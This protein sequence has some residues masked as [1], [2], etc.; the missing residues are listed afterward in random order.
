MHFMDIIKRN[1]VMTTTKSIFDVINTISHNNELIFII[2]D[3]QVD[4]KFA[5]LVQ[6]LESQNIICKLEK[7]NNELHIIIKE[8]AYKSSFISRSSWVPRILFAVVT[9]LVM[10]DGYYKTIE[11]N[12][13]IYIGNPIYI[14][15]IYTTSL[16]GILGTHELGH[17]IIAKMH[18]M[19]TTWPYFIPGIPIFGIPTFG[20]FIKSRN[21]ITNRKI[22][23]DVAIAG[24]IFGLITT[25][26]VLIYG[27]STAPILD[28]ETIQNMFYDNQI[29]E[30][31]E[32]FIMLF[33]FDKF[34]NNN[35]HILMTPILFASWIGFLIT[36]LNLL[37]AWQLDGGHMARS[38][39]GSKMHKI[40]TYSSIAFLFILGY[41]AMG[42]F[43]MLLY[44]LNPTI[45]I[46]DDVSNLPLNRKALYILVIFLIL[47][48]FP[49]PHNLLF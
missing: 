33:I 26:I 49:I 29:I 35:E 13:S 37:P 48:C 40:L 38:A 9:I 15:S 1:H 42:I 5:S 24:P 14:A 16:L 22:L 31:K 47:T 44:L 28:E 19:K 3:K 20:A 46:L 11:I 2:A 25:I 17:L 4:N 39:F 36:F 21:L 8:K 6:K 30:I 43:I 23:F 10:I 41:F 32:N 12:L 7:I 27:V 18:G 45:D 34:K